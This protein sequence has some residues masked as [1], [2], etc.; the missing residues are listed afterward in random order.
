[1]SLN[2]QND[3]VKIFID[4]VKHEYQEMGRLRNA[5]R[6]KMVQ[7]DKAQFPVLGDMTTAEHVLGSDI[8]T[9]NKDHTPVTITTKRFSAGAYCDRFLSMETNYDDRQETAKSLAM[10]FD[11][12]V[13]Q[14]IIDAL[15]ASAT[16]KT[17]ANN[18]SG[19]V[20]DLTLA[21][22]RSAAKQLDQDGVPTE[23]RTLL[24]HT[25]GLHHLLED[26]EVTSSD[27]NTIKALVQ[28]DLNTYYGFDIIKLG[29]RPN[30]G[31]LTIDGSNDRLNFAFHRDA[32]GALMSRD[33][34]IRVDYD[35]RKGA[36]LIT[37]FVSANAKEIDSKGIVKITTR[38]S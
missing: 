30:E 1:M 38:E 2:L 12:R 24:V 20:D 11:R 13:D 32:L 37:G 6:F 29:N 22:L 3:L 14:F 19:S 16:S 26:T 9:Q 31:G 21:A 8:P 25:N 28:G 4:E 36:D 15:E 17:V 7:G 5:V 35:A 18:V 33:I 23:G 10:A 34:E 27:Y